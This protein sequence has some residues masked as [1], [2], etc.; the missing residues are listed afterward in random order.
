MARSTPKQV[1]ASEAK[2]RAAGQREIRVYVPDRDIHGSEA[3]DDIRRK[4]AEW[5]DKLCPV[6]ADRKED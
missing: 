6:K 4:A 3:E 5:C 2:R 1:R